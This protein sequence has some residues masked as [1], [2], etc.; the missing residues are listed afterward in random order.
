MLDDAHENTTFMFPEFLKI[1]RS[2]S[3]QR[4]RPQ[5]VTPFL[6]PKKPEDSY[7]TFSQLSYDHC[8]RLVEP[9]G[10]EPVTSCLQ[11]RRSPS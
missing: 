5:A 11:S 4:R 9:T 10:I 8:S 7:D 3:G 2:L 1:S 6:L